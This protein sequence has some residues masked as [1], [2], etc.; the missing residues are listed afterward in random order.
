MYAPQPRPPPNTDVQ[1][2]LGN[3]TAASGLWTISEMFVESPVDGAIDFIAKFLAANRST[4]AFGF[5][6]QNA[7]RQ[8]FRVSA[9][10]TTVAGTPV[11]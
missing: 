10:P 3:L 11:C 5:P 9:P 6:M 1:E 7:L 8:A 4:T 2:L